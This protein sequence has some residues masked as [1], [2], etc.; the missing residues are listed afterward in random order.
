MSGPP[1]R[2]VAGRAPPDAARE[3]SVLR[4]ATD[5]ASVAMPAKPAATMMTVTARRLSLDIAVSVAWPTVVVGV[6]IAAVVL[7]DR[8]GVA[9]RHG[10]CATS[11]GRFPFRG[12]RRRRR[13]FLILGGAVRL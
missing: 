7:R 3:L 9:L 13:A 11:G 6:L 8:T 12:A 5:T 2:P 1:A 10:R 4:A